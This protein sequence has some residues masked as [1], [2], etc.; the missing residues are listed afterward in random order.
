VTPH[1]R[2]MLE[3]EAM[4]GLVADLEALVTSS[5]VGTVPA[6]EVADAFQR[7]T[8]NLPPESKVLAQFQDL[9]SR[10]RHGPVRTRTEGIRQI[11]LKLR[12]KAEEFARVVEARDAKLKPKG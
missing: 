9:A 6:T 11:A 12:I 10:L 7:H 3:I 5:N 1:K 2:R 8:S 4:R